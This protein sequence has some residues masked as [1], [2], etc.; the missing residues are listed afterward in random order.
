M[1][2]ASIKLS[3]WSH[4]R[5]TIQRFTAWSEYLR[6]STL[7]Q[8]LVPKEY[9][10][11]DMRFKVFVVASVNVTLFRNVTSFCLVVRYLRFERNELSPSLGSSL[12]LG[13]SGRQI[14]SKCWH[15]LSAKLH[16]T[17]HYI[18][19][20]AFISWPVSGP[21]VKQSTCKCETRLFFQKKC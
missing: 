17:P 15:V 12:Y 4:R 21:F 11:S 10:F 5:L 14:T 1:H 8:H 18:D 20:Y 7:L 13:K 16:V 9:H 6:Y 3:W 19:L 2:E